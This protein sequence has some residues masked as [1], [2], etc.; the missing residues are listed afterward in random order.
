[1]PR[2]PV[3]R[4]RSRVVVFAFACAAFAGA[5]A[6]H[7]E[8]ASAPSA[9]DSGA[10]QALPGDASLPPAAWLLDASDDGWPVLGILGRSSL[11]VP[12]DLVVDMVGDP[13]PP[14]CNGDVHLAAD[15]RGT[16]R[17]RGVLEAFH[18]DPSTLG[19]VVAAVLRA[20]FFDLQPEYGTGAPGVTITISMNQQTKKVHHRFGDML[21]AGTGRRA[22]AGAALVLTGDRERLVDL[23]AK[24]N[25]AAH[26][27]RP[28]DLQLPAANATEK[29]CPKCDAGLP[30][31]A[32]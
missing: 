25:F 11:A 22:D 30:R 26:L 6:C 28:D 7:E 3:T 4:L 15:G 9:V 29:P 27:G 32:R 19:D 20:R 2:R 18:V 12:T 10:V 1:M 5:Y 23:Q 8:P 17:R 13:C 24:I 16:V 14:R 31:G 21:A